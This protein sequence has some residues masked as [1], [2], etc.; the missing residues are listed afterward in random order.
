MDLVARKEEWEASWRAWVWA[1]SGLNDW[2][3]SLLIHH[4][5]EYFK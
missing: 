2:F 3:A 4:C 1:R 5:R